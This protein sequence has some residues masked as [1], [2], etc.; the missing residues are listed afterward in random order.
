MTST[1]PRAGSCCIAPL[2]VFNLL[3]GQHATCQALKGHSVVSC[4]QSVQTCGGAAGSMLLE[5]CL[6]HSQPRVHCLNCCAQTLPALVCT[7]TMGACVLFYGVFMGSSATFGGSPVCS[8]SIPSSTTSSTGSDIWMVQR[9]CMLCQTPAFCT[10]HPAEYAM[11]CRQSR[12]AIFGGFHV[13]TCSGSS[14][15]SSSTGFDMWM[16]QRKCMLCQTPAF[17]TVHP[18]DYVMECRQSRALA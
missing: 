15:T 11:Q 3:C 9:K 4:R 16:V 1:V 12:A 17:C 18:A 10:V 6:L 2:D 8:C 7:V 13:C 14:S 5:S